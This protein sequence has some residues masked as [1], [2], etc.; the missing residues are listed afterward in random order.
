MRHGISAMSLALAFMAP[1]PRLAEDRSLREEPEPPTEPEVPIPQ[2]TE[3]GPIVLLDPIL[4]NLGR[5]RLRANQARGHH[6][7]QLQRRRGRSRR[8]FVRAK[9]RA[10]VARRG[11]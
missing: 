2:P 1:A 5:F 10:R 4:E 6:P 9:R 11:W 7:C 3:Q 8:V